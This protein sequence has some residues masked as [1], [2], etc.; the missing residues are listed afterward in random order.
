MGPRSRDRGIAVLVVGTNGIVTLQWGRGHVTAESTRPGHLG[1]QL[2]R[3]NG[4]AVT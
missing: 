1:A 2:V 4:A 3:F